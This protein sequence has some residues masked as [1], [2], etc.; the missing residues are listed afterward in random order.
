MTQNLQFQLY[1]AIIHLLKTNLKKG[2]KKV[3]F[4]GFGNFSYL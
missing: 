1:F 2:T 3:L 4:D